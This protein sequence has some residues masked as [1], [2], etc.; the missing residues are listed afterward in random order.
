MKI[1]HIEPLL[2]DP[3]LIVLD[4]REPHEIAASGTLAGAIHIPIGQLESRLA[5][6]PRDKRILTA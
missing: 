3:D 4:V 5:E 6:L 1:D 2:N